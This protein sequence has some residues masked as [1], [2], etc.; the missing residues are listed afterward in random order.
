M[1]PLA[2]LSESALRVSCP[3]TDRDGRV[4]ESCPKSMATHPRDSVKHH[5]N[6]PRV[7]Q[8]SIRRAELMP[9][10]HPTHIS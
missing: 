4:L 10:E 5:P 1:F 2:G 8:M 9:S 3:Q 6:E 7:M